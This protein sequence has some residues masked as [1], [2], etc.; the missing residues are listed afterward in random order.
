MGSVVEFTVAGAPE[1][2]ARKVIAEAVDDLNFM[3]STFHAW[4]EGPVARM[5]VNFS[6]GGKFAAPTSVLPLVEQS[7]DLSEKSGRLFN[8][9]LG[10]LFALW[11]WQS[12]DLPKGPPPSAQQIAEVLAQNARMTDIAIDGIEASSRNP[13]VKLDFGAYAQGYAAD[14]IIELFRER[15][16]HNAIVNVSGDVRTIGG[17]GDRPWR[18][19]VRHPRG[20]GILASVEMRDDEALVTSGDYERFYEWEGV[21]YHHI[22]DPRTGQPA[23]GAISVTV[24]HA[25]TAV[26]DAAATALMIAGEN[27]WHA[28]ARAMGIKRVML[29]DPQRRVH[30]DPETA[31]RVK[32]EIDPPPVVLVSEP[33]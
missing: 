30:M 31:K 28:V 26:A 17:N 16:I 10:K 20:D 8:P 15:G 18:I 9:A 25:S 29:V 21:R 3:H 2:L 33:L 4:N 14:R 24:L 13:H 22:L 12:D 1:S 19:G 11:G 32:F 7:T 27:E 6:V 23:R 5:N